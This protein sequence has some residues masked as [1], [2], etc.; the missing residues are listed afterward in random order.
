MKRGKDDDKIT[1][2]M[3][4][5]L[6]VNDTDKGGP[7]APPRNKM[8]LYEQLSIPSQRFNPD[9]LSRNPSNTSDSAPPGSS[10]QGSGLERHFHYPHHVPP[11]TPTR[12]AE[13]H[14]SHQPDGG[15]LNT[16]VAL[17]TQRKMVGEEDFTV[18][19]FVHSGKGQ[20]QTKMQTSA[21][22]E[23]LDSL[24][25]AYLGHS[26]RI[27]NVGDNGCIGSTGLNLRPHTRHQS[28]D[29]LE[30]CVSSS[31]HIARHSTNL[32]T[33]EKNYMPGEANASQKNQQY[34][35]NLVSNFTRLQGNDTCLQKETSGRLQ[36]NHSEHDDHVPELRSQ[37]EKTNI[38]QPGNDSHL[39]KDC[40]S[41]NEPEID[42]ECFGDKTCGSLQFR[43]G[44]RSND[45]SETSMV[46]SISTLDISPDDVVGIIG[47]K[48]FWKA[49]RA[50]ANQQRVFSVQVFELHRLIKVQRLIAGSPHLLL[51]DEVHQAKPPV[52]SSPCKNLPSECV[53]T[54]PVHVGKRKDIS[55]NPNSKMECSAENAVG[56][57][58]FFSLKNGQPPNFM[59]HAGPTTV[60]MAADTK[61]APCCFHPSPGHQWLVPVMSPSEGLVYKPY[62][63]PA[64]MGPGCGGYGPFGS[65]PLTGNFMTS[66]YGVPTSHY[67]QGIG[68]LPGASPVGNACF[69]PYGM[70]GMNPAISGSVVEQMNY[71][72]GSGSCGQTAQYPGGILSS[73]M[74][75]QSSSTEQ[76]QKSEAVLQGMK[77]QA[78]KNTSVVK[79][80]SGRVQGVGTVQSADGSAAL[81]PFPVTP[82]PERAPQLQETD[83]L[84][85]VIKVVPHNGRSA[86][87]SAARIFQSIQEGRKQ[88]ETL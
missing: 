19:V 73:N 44:D 30:V 79:S 22:Q 57:T 69:P 52:K 33:R 8:A 51:E 9:A 6:H 39:R 15:N 31:D 47:Q 10:S 61:M 65:I 60:P 29:N 66:A 4:P 34:R 48:H 58:S 74:Q 28:E 80:P 67:H 26:S 49:R 87:E 78:S 83:Q 85:K 11:P 50:I 75:H 42:S 43:K 16:P 81:P 71:F 41:P 24:C 21:A 40:S 18:P 23:K 36:S 82:S 45:A 53:V 77:L 46:D 56:K 88:Y 68:F 3:F 63:A 5:R 12:V 38:S 64:I 32:Q 1:G 2:P 86:T 76:T 37:K 72:A 27:Q 14:H 7:R 13:K 62:T 17:L 84:S 54:P 25:S 55:E 70:P 35:N 59:P 20:S